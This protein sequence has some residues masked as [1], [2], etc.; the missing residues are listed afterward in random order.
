MITL[1]LVLA[2]AGF[3]LVIVAIARLGGGSNVGTVSLFAAS[4]MPPRPQGVQEVDLPRFVFHD[5]PTAGS[6]AS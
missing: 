4:A 5:S 1:T 2:V 3:V 6:S